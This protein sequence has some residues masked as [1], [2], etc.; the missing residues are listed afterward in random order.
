MIAASGI[1][2]LS[3]PK[4]LAQTGNGGGAARICIGIV[5]FLNLDISIKDA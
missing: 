1:L 3:I 5:Y 2:P 4:G